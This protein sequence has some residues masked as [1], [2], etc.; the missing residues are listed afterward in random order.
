M[1]YSDKD[2]ENDDGEEFELRKL[3]Y[4]NLI[5]N[6]R[7]LWAAL[8]GALATTVYGELEPIMSLRVLDYGVSD[9]QIGL[10]FGIAPLTYAVGCFLTPFIPKWVESRVTMI[11]GTIFVGLSMGLINPFF[12]DQSMISMC[13]GLGLFSFFIAP[14]SIPNMPEMM[15]AMRE[16]YPDYDLEHADSLLSGMMMASYSVG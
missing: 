4:S 12:E 8:T 16:Q 5:C 9:F 7:V 13:I 6:Q 10:I 2:E 14:M 15:A 1:E 11:I 3:G